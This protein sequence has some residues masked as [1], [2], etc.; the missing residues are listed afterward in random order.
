MPLLR[1]AAQAASVRTRLLFPLL[2]TP[3]LL[4]ACTTGQAADEP[5]GVVA[6]AT[7][8]EGGAAAEPTPNIIR[9]AEAIIGAQFNNRGWIES[10]VRMEMGDDAVFRVVLDRPTNTLSQLDAYTQMCRALSVLITS[11]ANPTG[12]LAIQFFKADGTPMVGTGTPDSEC[13]RF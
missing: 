8:E 9:Q 6:G 12:I 4:V 10:I 11:E 7:V 2:L 5:E 13:S 1:A 3:L